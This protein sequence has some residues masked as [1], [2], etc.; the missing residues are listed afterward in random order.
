MV[1]PEIESTAQGGDCHSRSFAF[2]I[3]SSL[4]NHCRSTTARCRP[5]RGDRRCAFKPDKLINIPLLQRIPAEGGYRRKAIVA[6][7]GVA[8]AGMAGIAMN[9]VWLHMHGHPM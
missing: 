5:D 4:T 3:P 8:L 7:C 1:H 9:L 6:L 2:V